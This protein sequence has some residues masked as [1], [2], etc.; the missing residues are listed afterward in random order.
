MPPFLLDTN[1]LVHAMYKGS[2]WHGEAARLVEQGLH[3]AGGSV[4]RLR[5]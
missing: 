2:A 4:S 5:T 3:S 1:V